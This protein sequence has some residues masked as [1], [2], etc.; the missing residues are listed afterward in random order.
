MFLQLSGFIEL[1]TQAKSKCRHFHRTENIQR[2]LRANVVIFAGSL[3]VIGVCGCMASQHFP[4]FLYFATTS[5]MIQCC[6]AAEGLPIYSNT[7]SHCVKKCEG[8][9]YLKVLHGHSHKRE[10]LKTTTFALPSFSILSLF[11]I[12]TRL[13][14]FRE[15]GSFLANYKSRIL[16]YLVVEV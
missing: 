10:P 15:T 3:L 13:R 6:R 2:E 11:S 8:K 16:L 1:K 14:V 7:F 12:L 9:K 5:Q 4:I